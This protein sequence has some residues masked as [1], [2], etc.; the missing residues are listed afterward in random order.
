MMSYAAA[1]SK[2][3]DQFVHKHNLDLDDRYWPLSIREE[4]SEIFNKFQ[5]TWDREDILSQSSET[6]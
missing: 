2:L 4:W 3:F 6:D 1:Y 5:I